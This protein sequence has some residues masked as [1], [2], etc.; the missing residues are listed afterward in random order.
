MISA[1]THGPSC[2][3][4]WFATLTE[5][6]WRGRIVHPRGMMTCELPHHPVVIDMRRPVLCIPER[7]LSYKFMAA[8][9]F[10]ILSWD[11]TVAGIEPWN[12]NIAKFSDDG[13]KFAGA[14]G[15][16][17]HE[18]LAYTVSKLV[19]DPDTRQAGFTIWRNN[20]APTKDYPCTVACW[21]QIRDGHLEMHVFMR[22]SDIWLGL[23][24]DLFNFSMLGHYVTAMLRAHGKYQ[25]LEPGNLFLTAASSHLYQEHFLTAQQ[26][27][28]RGTFIQS[29]PTPEKLFSTETALMDHL[30][31][32]RD[33]KPGDPLR[34]WECEYANIT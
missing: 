4:A 3:V 19:D 13:V 12:K 21:F 26:I 14:Y 23:P 18:S 29:N 10:W 24:Y 31:Q 20:P 17:I 33:T 5:V 6:A 30:Q 34:W 7:K 2:D 16:R 32:L 1:Y 27:I 28:E 8:E 9:A 11:E 25:N 15:P 22:S